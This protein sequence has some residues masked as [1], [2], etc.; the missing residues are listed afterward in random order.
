MQP[1]LH[2]GPAR[3]RPKKR[4]SP[5][6]LILRIVGWTALAAAVV[7]G[8]F[9]AYQMWYTNVQAGRAQDRLGSEFA[10]RVQAAAPITGT[11]DP[12]SLPLA[13]IVV[14]SALDTAAGL[15]AGVLP[16]GEDPPELILEAAP[17][18]G[19]PIGTILIPKARVDWVVVEGGRRSDLT[20]GAGHMPWTPLPGQPGNAVIS[21]HRTTYGAPFRHLDDLEPGDIVTVT[22]TIGTH[23]YQVVEVRAVDP[24]DTWVMD[25]WRGAWLTLTTCHP[26]FLATQ[27]LVAI[28]RLIDGPNAE[29]ILGG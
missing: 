2:G 19:G 28:S 15:D 29:A 13:P 18:L 24:N 3:V 17:A 6:A 27:R 12:E 16:A 11:Y 7:L 21:G 26:E 25:Q 8:G 1:T 9:V 10:L 20:L 22:T 14:P 23:I 4:R 5:A